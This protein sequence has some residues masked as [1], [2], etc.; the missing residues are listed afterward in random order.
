MLEKKKKK[1]H[2]IERSVIDFGLLVTH[3]IISYI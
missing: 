1:N 3:I 2:I